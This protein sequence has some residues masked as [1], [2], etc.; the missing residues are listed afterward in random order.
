MRQKVNTPQINRN[1]YF[2]IPL[3][4]KVEAVDWHMW[5]TIL[6]STY[7][8]SASAVYQRS[9]ERSW[10]T[11]MPQR[12]LGNP[13]GEQDAAFIKV[14]VPLGWNHISVYEEDATGSSPGFIHEMSLTLEYANA[15]TNQTLS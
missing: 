15:K 11:N 13:L 12:H 6:S 5:W 1:P 8:V 10:I 14:A 3:A 4:A 7:D 2:F 9:Q